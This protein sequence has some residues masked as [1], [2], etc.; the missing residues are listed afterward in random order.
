MILAYIHISY[1]IDRRHMCCFSVG[2]QIMRVFELKTVEA[3]TKGQSMR[4]I[5][6]GDFLFLC[7]CTPYQTTKPSTKYTQYTHSHN[8]LYAQNIYI[9]THTIHSH[10]IHTHPIHHTI[11]TLTK[12]TH[13]IKTLRQYTQAHSSHIHTLT[14]PL[15]RG[16]LKC[17]SGVKLILSILNVNCFIGKCRH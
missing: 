1:I 2:D 13:T 5:H 8:A 10:N 7:L 11:H 6:F 15:Q 4:L 16:L 14:R 12:Y 9:H 17:K 3:Y